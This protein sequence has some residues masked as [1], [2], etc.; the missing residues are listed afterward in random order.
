[1]AAATPKSLGK[2]AEKKSSKEKVAS[3][4]KMWKGKKK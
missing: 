3:K 1:V 2:S 4:A